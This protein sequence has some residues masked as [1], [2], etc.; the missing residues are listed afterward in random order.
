MHD[1]EQIQRWMQTVI[2]HLNGVESGVASAE[3]RRLIDVA[4]TEVEQ[5]VTRSR[6][7]AA[8]D[9]LEIYNRAYFARLVE[10]LR[11]EYP[12]LLHALGDEAFD[13][14]AVGYLY[15]HPSRSYTLNHLGTHFPRYLEESRPTSLRV[16]VGGAPRPNWPDFL[17]DLAR[18]ELTFNE[19]F[20]GPGV[21]GQRLLEVERVLQVPP[22]RWPEARLVPVPCLR[23]LALRHP[24]HRYF[25]AVRKKRKPPIPR[26]VETF[27]AVTRRRYV[28]RRYQLSRLQYVLLDELVAGQS[29]GEAIEKTAE[30]AGSELDELADHLR[31][32]FRNWTAEGFFQ[33]IETPA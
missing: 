31:E 33:A 13:S 18:L 27:L 24:V 8:L 2:M 6:A 7:L 3:A 14:F 30:A 25:R 19:V 15:E 9:R 29:V 4:P 26:P 22:A 10:C 21:E 12:V 23:L 1:L 17:I 20:D 16:Q 28:V 11:E 32:W 5:V